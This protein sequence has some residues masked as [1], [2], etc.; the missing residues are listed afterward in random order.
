[1]GRQRFKYAIAPHLG[2]FLEANVV[3][4]G[5]NFN[6]E[7][8]LLQVADMESFNRQISSV[9][10]EG[11]SNIILSNIKR[12]EDDEE[13]DG[14]YRLRNRSGKSIILRVYES[15]GGFGK[16][17]IKT[18]FNVQKAFKTNFLEDDEEEL[19]AKDGSIAISS[20]NLRS[21]Q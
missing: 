15:L 12:G 2:S 20:K 13:L 3:Q 14:H 5:L 9:T 1:M 11:P 6:N 8:R 4:A 16:A 18:K 10:L 7:L 19:M 21:S 17:K